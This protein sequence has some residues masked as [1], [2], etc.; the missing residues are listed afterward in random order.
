M[1]PDLKGRRIIF[2]VNVYIEAIR[3]GFAAE[4]SQLLLSSIPHTYLSAVVVQELYAGALD[5]RGER[6]VATIVSQTERT[7]RIVI[8]TYRD[9]K[10]TGRILGTINRQEPG[11]RTRIPRLVNDVLLALS[12]VQIGATLCTLNEEDFIL[13]A[14]YKKFSLELLARG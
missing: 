9:W 14:C 3:R 6:L 4:L 1:P 5:S 2:D 7:G 10:E 8:P 13:I 11:E 12:A